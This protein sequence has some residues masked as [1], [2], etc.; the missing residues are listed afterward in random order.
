MGATLRVLVRNLFPSPS[1]RGQG[2]GD[3]CNFCKPSS[4]APHQQLR[5]PIIP[6]QLS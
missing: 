5:H 1:G 4:I 3:S 2:E 6:M